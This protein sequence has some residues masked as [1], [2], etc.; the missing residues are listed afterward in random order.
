MEKVKRKITYRLYPS[1]KQRNQMTEILRLHQ[2]LYNAALE[3]RIDAYKRCRVSLNYNDQ[4]KELTTLRAEFP[5]Y[6][7]LNAQS[8]QVT[9]RRLERS[10]Q[11]FFRRVKGGVEKAGFPRF[12]SFERYKGWG[13]AAHG[14][15]WKFTIG[16]NGINGSL[17]VSG[18]G[19]LQARGR[20]R[21]IDKERTSRSPGIPKTMEIVR[22]NEKWYASITFETIA[23]YRESGNEALGIDWGTSQFLNIVNEDQIPFVI[24]NP[25]HLKNRQDLLKSRQRM[26]SRKKKGSKNWQKA[27]QKIASAFER[28]AWKREDFLHQ[29]SASVIKR[30]RFIA[31]ETLQIKNMTAHGGAYKKGLNRSIL[32]TAP[33]KFFMFLEF[34]AADAGIPYIEVPTRKIKPSQTCSGCGNVK[35]KLLSERI[36]DCTSC[37]KRL[38]RDINAATVILN[39]ALTGSV[40]GREPTLGAEGEVTHPLKHETPLIPLG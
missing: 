20:G 17:R 30:A 40:T 32:D 11:N 2:R 33:G 22:K 14:D 5:D 9:L 23:P 27:K 38:D 15:G 21:F 34:K 8:E 24:E 12:K 35:K 18:V 19:N 29:T 4:A 37:G 26:L 3:Q 25:R 13:Y 36:H 16:V 39:Y 7:A 6:A 10:F 1:E 31:T 28:L